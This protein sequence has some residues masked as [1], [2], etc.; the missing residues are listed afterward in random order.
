MAPEAQTLRVSLIILRGLTIMILSD[1]LLI[2]IQLTHRLMPKLL[3]R[4]WM[5][6]NAY[7]AKEHIL[8]FHTDFY[9]EIRF[10]GTPWAS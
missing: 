9:K 6:S 1:E 5:V 10:Y 2:D 8:P 3:L 4:S 7:G